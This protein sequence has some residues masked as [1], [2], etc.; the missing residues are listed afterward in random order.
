M[1]FN[2]EY[3]IGCMLCARA[4]VYHIPLVISSV[5]AYAQQ[6]GVCVCYAEVNVCMIRARVCIT[7]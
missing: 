3:T 4:R 2:I 1:E 7:K 5:Y 6:G